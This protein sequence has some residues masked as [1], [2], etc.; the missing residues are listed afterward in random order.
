LVTRISMTSTGY[1]ATETHL[2]DIYI[3]KKDFNTMI[4]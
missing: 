3:T 1:L 4:P 2:R